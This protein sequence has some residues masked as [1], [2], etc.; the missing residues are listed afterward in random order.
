M[1]KVMDL[2]HELFH[3]RR[4]SIRK[5]QHSMLLHTQ[6]NF[7]LSCRTLTKVSPV[8]PGYNDVCL[9]DTLPITSD[10]LRY[11]LIPHC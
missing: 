11:Q 7:M 6:L 10:I 5:C 8:V 4:F 1:F 2:P 9:Y 3:R